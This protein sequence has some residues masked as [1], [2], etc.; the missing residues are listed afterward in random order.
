[1]AGAEA[2]VGESGGKT[3]T[4][5]PEHYGEGRGSTKVKSPLISDLPP[6]LTP[7]HKELNTASIRGRLGGRRGKSAEVHTYIDFCTS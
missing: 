3:G 5:E 2:T 6:S 1:M 7:F 4:R